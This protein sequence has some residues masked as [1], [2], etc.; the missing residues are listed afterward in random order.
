MRCDIHFVHSPHS[1]VS[2]VSRPGR[3]LDL[4]TSQVDPIDPVCLVTK[5][6]I[7][8]RQLKPLLVAESDF[9]N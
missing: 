9:R 4:F 6:V 3:G 5:A 1:S 7:P 2:C 8:V